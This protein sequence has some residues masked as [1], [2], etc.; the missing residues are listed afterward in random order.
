[1]HGNAGSADFDLRVGVAQDAE[2]NRPGGHLDLI[3]VIFEVAEADF[4]RGAQADQV[5]EIELDFGAGAVGGDQAVAGGQGDVHD[6]GYQVPRVAAA[7]RNVPVHETD[8]GYAAIRSF[9]F[10]IRRRLANPRIRSRRLRRPGCWC[11]G[12]LWIRRLWIWSLRIRRLSDRLLLRPGFLGRPGLRRLSQ[13]GDGQDRQNRGW[14]Q[15]AHSL[16][17][18]GLQSWS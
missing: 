6:R 2:R 16:A 17:A 14:N 7:D 1:M 10:I 4:G 8:A 11:I 12:A 18:G 3:A 15:E 5:G 13:G 9:A